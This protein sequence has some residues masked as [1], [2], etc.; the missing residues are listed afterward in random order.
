LIHKQRPSQV[1]TVASPMPGTVI[2]VNCRT[3]DS[4]N[5]G[6][7]L[8]TIEAMKMQNLIKSPRVGIVSE[9]KVS[10]GDKVSSNQILLTFVK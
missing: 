6:D 10:I 2:S 9:I 3:G 4:V 5:E 7:E 1:D 8:F